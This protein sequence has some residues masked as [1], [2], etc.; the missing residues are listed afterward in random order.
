MMQEAISK[1]TM[2]E[3]SIRELSAGLQGKT[4]ILSLG[5]DDFYRSRLTHSMEVAQIAEG[6]VQQ[7]RVRKLPDE[8]PEQLPPAAL[9]QAIGLAHD[10]GH[11]PLVMAVS[12]P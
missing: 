12:W 6:I 7:L 8:M 11:P 1:S 10:I 9:I 4:Q 2:Q 3:S 5:D